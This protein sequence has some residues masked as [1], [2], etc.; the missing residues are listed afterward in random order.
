MMPPPCPQVFLENLSATDAIKQA[1]VI[2]A[3]FVN[4]GNTC[5]MNATLEVCQLVSL[6]LG[7]QGL[8]HPHSHLLA[9]V[10]Q[11]LRQVPELRNALSEYKPD[12]SD[13]RAALT[14]TLGRTY[15]EADASTEEKPVPPMLFLGLLRQLNPTF[16]HRNERGAYSQQVGASRSRCA[17]SVSTSSLT[18]L[19]CVTPRLRMRMSSLVLSCLPWPHA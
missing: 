1:H 15:D 19:C 3:G 7:H 8:L 11:C 6:S 5:Y 10:C 12:P 14:A 17:V 9:C 16:A 18:L 13:P 4:L 2:P